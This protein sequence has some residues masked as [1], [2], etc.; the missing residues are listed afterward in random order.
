MEMWDKAEKDWIGLLVR[1]ET[2]GRFR[3]GREMRGEK[4]TLSI[5]RKAER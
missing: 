5:Y 1:V 2:S 4:S 3:R